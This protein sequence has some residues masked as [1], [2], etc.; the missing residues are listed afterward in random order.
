MK[1]NLEILHYQLSNVVEIEKIKR[2]NKSDYVK[3]PIFFEKSKFIS[4]HLVIIKPELIKE[5]PTG[6]QNVLLICLGEPIELS[7]DFTF[8]ILVV[9][10]KVSSEQIF[11]ILQSIFDLFDEWDDKLKTINNED[12]GFVEVIESCKSVTHSPLSLIDDDFSYVAY[13]KDTSKKMGL[14]DKFVDD[15]NY[16]PLRNVNEIISQP[17]YEAEKKVKESLFIVGDQSIVAKNVFYK[18]QYVGRISAIME[19]NSLINDYNAQILFHINLYIEDMYSRYKGFHQINPKMDALHV[20][21]TD[22]LKGETFSDLSWNS[23]MEKLE[24]SIKDEYVLVQLKHGHTYSKELYVEYMCPQLE[25]MWKGTSAFPYENNIVLLI[26]LTVFHENNESSFNQ[27]LSYFLRESLTIA[28]VSRE[29]YNIGSIKIAFNQ[30]E[31]ALKYGPE[32]DTMLWAFYFDNYVLDYIIDNGI[33]KF[34][35]KDLCHKG[36]LK[37]RAHDSKTGSELYKTLFTFFKVNFNASLAAE[38]LKIHRSTFI[39]RM[40]RI[41]SLTGVNLDDLNTRLYLMMSFQMTFQ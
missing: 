9:K 18:N 34:K 7:E 24:W 33:R 14:V 35:A 19:K 23:A 40:E 2:K 11:N 12:L 29:F 30:S 6:V 26:N 1:L 20:M 15:Y 5:I 3:R 13:S 10:K 31:I 27:T 17:N 39:N 28:G 21:L 38:K 8:D 4:G 22:S 36:L 25:K 41:D 32:K 16:I 37:I